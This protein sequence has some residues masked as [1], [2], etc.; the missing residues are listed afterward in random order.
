[1]P[2]ITLQHWGDGQ[3]ALQ[4]GVMGIH[5]GEMVGSWQGMPRSGVQ[6]VVSVIVVGGVGMGCTGW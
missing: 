4:L 1:M 2:V 3:A 6:G 5:E